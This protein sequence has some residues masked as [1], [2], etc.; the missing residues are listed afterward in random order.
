MA[1]DPLKINDHAFVTGALSETINQ[2]R[3][4]VP[5]NPGGAINFP[6]ERSLQTR[7]ENMQLGIP[8]DDGVWA[9]VRELAAL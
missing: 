3:E 5:A 4:S 9:K 2:L 7:T 6:G 8:V 1:F